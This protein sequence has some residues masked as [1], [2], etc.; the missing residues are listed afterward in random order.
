VLIIFT[1][2]SS[3]LHQTLEN[4]YASFIVTEY[5][6]F[7][8]ELVVNFHWY[9]TDRIGNDR[10]KNYSIVALDF[11][12]SVVQSEFLAAHSEVL[13]SIPGATKFSA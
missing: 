6:K 4:L 1:E 2:E 9:D 5:K 7:R 10:S 11:T 13:G 8:Q 12:A 3:A